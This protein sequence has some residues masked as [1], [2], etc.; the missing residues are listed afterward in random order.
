MKRLI[1]GC[2]MLAL[3]TGCQ[4]GVTYDILTHDNVIAAAKEARK[5]VEA[6]NVAVVT[7]TAMRKEQMLQAVGKGIKTL[8]QKQAIDTEQAEKLAQEVMASLR[9]HL[10]NYAEQE[11]RR[12]SLY[13]ITIDNLDYIIQISE[14]GKKYTIYKADVGLQWKQYLESSARRAIGTIE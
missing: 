12:A 13:A 5:G 10:S 4:A 7:G 9:T 11:R 8:A 14:Q 6:F 3:F 1:A 2:I